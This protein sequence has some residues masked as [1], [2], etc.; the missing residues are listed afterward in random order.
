M[1]TALIGIGPAWIIP[2]LDYNGNI[3]TINVSCSENQ[4]DFVVESGNIYLESNDPILIINS[5]NGSCWLVIIDD[6]GNLST[7]LT[8]CPENADLEVENGNLVLQG[9]GNGVILKSTN[10]SCWLLK[11]NIGQSLRSF[12]I[13]CLSNN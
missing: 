1:S 5:P 8:N 11:I 6:E 9:A 7:I 13:N 12:R 10:G 3:Q 2:T 4:N